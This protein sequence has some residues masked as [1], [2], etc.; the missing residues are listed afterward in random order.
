M[1]LANKPDAERK[2]RRLVEPPFERVDVVEDLL[3]VGVGRVAGRLEL[4]HG[5]QGRL[6]PLDTSR[7]KGFA[8]HVRADQQVGVR[9]Q[10]PHTE[11]R[12]QRRFSIGEQADRRR[13]QRERARNWS[14][15]EG[16]V[17]VP[18]DRAPR[19]AERSRSVV[20]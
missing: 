18:A 12:S 19:L 6:G 14:R 7:G 15:E 4:Q 11:E 13:R 3:Y 5:E 20:V 1:H 9:N 17:A 10:L 8:Q 2:P 16:D